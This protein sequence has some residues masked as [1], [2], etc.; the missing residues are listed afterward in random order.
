LFGYSCEQ[1]LGLDRLS[2]TPLQRAIEHLQIADVWQHRVSAFIH[3]ELQTTAAFP[4]DFD[5]LFKH[6]ITRTL[7]GQAEGE[8]DG[9]FVFRVHVDLGVRYIDKSASDAAVEQGDGVPEH[10]GDAGRSDFREPEILAQIE[11]IYV[12]E[13]RSDEDL[14]EDAL[15]AFAFQNASY[16]VWPFWREFLASQCN[17]M[18]LPRVGLPIRSVKQLAVAEN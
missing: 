18:N 9:P 6:A 13:Y 1:R 5:L 2:Q 14:P 17:R 12:A 10:V 4:E 3:D 11:A 8:S 15:K 7:Y 16:H